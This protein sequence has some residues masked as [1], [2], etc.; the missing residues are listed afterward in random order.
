VSTQRLKFTANTNIILIMIC[1]LHICQFCVNLYFLF[2]HSLLSFVSNLTAF[3][4]TLPFLNCVLKYVICFFVNTLPLHN[5]NT[6]IFSFMWI[7]EAPEKCFLFSIAILIVR[8]W[9]NQ[10]FNK[11]YHLIIYLLLL[12]LPLHIFSLAHLLLLHMHQTLQF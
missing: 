5:Y 3:Y 6:S 7:W 9:I 4:L 8:K 1:N 11:C 2:F 12:S 10:Y